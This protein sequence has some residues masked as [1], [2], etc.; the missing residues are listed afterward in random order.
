MS[1]NSGAA[2]SALSWLLFGSS[3]MTPTTNLGLSADRMPAKVV[4]FSVR[5]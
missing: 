5:L 1:W 4:V 3:S 2:V